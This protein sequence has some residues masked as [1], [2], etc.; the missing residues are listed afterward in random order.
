[1]VDFLLYHIHFLNAHVLFFFFLLMRFFTRLISMGER[2]PTSNPK[3]WPDCYTSLCFLFRFPWLL[4]KY[5]IFVLSCC[6]MLCSFFNRGALSF[7]MA[8]SSMHCPKTLHINWRAESLMWDIKI[9]LSG[10][11]LHLCSEWREGAYDLIS[12]ISMATVPLLLSFFTSTH[13]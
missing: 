1:M 6:S 7:S 8:G 13:I 4:V 12:L 9:C 3:P 2:M 5:L 11:P 10:F